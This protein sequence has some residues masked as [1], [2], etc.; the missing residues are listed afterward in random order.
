MLKRLLCLLLA[1]ALSVGFFSCRGKEDTDDTTAAANTAPPES[2]V[3]G[4]P[5]DESEENGGDIPRPPI[6]DGLLVAR[7][8]ERLVLDGKPLV[9][10]DIPAGLKAMDYTVSVPEGKQVTYLELAGWVGYV[11]AVD[12]FG[13]SVDGGEITYGLFA[14]HTEEEI[15]EAG[16]EYAL[17]YT[18]TVP[19]LSLKA[20]THTVRFLA[21]LAD[22]TVVSLMEELRIRLESVTV[23]PT[24]AYHSSVTGLGGDIPEEIRVYEGRGGSVDRGVDIID[25]TLDGISI[26]QN[27]RLTVSGWL[28][29]EGGVE[30]YV[31]S[32]DGVTWYPAESNGVTG[33]PS[34]GHFASLGYENATAHALMT[35]LTLDL[36]PCAGRNAAI[37]VGGV[38][39]NAPDRV[40]PF[41]T[42][43]GLEIPIAPADIDFSYL[44]YAD[45]NDEGTDLAS[46]DLRYLFDVHYGAGDLRHVTRHDGGLC[47]CYSGIHSFQTQ[48]DGCFALTAKVSAM[49]GCSFL[50][51]RATKE[52]RSVDEVPIPLHAFYETDG[53]G[54]CGGAGIFAQLSEGV[55]T[56]VI[57][58]LDPNAPYRVKNCIYRYP[59]EGERLTLADDGSTV[60]VLVDGREI[61]RITV[62]GQTEYPEHF[63]RVAPY[64]R[65]A[66][67]VTLTLPD[68]KTETIRN[69]LVASTV[70]AH[71]GV[72]VRGGSIHFTELS[73]VPFSEAGLR[74]ESH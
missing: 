56:V 26:G 50:F 9:E 16:G 55:V 33:E 67:S 15:R 35:D 47:Y 7:S 68:G 52:V 43:T 30:R 73:V 62:R 1:A 48:T 29:L 13:Y 4:E 45:Y 40:V 12:A 39:Q 65:F 32:A 10:G 59:A 34:A 69:T 22:G 72:A 41:L 38:P 36:T 63:A 51:V 42:V 25:A 24:V 71:C 49:T 11:M 23:D 58:A 37:T 27:R 70:L 19:L 2:S 6:D 74:T 31:W 46:S 66:S 17:R 5:P 54:L 20:G 28:A 60:Y 21:R 57:K 61:T 44:T 14:T 18:V 8:P 53:A 3:T 64:V